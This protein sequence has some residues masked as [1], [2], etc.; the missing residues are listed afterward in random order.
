[1]TTP[2]EDIRPEPQRV[3]PGDWRRAAAAFLHLHRSDVEGLNAIL[4][5]ADEGG[6]L[7]M[8]LLATL[9]IAR[10]AP[11]PLDSDAGVLGLQKIVA[12]MFQAES[13]L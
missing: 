7:S 5:E 11:A 13:E 4:S 12:Q 9:Y 10:L 3:E 1:M 8:L 6:R 2:S